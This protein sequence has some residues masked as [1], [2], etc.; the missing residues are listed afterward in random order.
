M[1][2]SEHKYSSK[3]NNFDLKV[4]IFHNIYKRASI[5]EEAKGTAYPTILQGLALDHYYTI[6]VNAIREY[7][8]NFR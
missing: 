4:A 6:V 2:I 7:S 8:L 5:P 1:Y 3:G